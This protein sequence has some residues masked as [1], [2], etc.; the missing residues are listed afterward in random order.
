[1]S[2][3]ESEKKRRNCAVTLYLGKTLKGYEEGCI[4]VWGEKCEKIEGKNNG[5]S[6]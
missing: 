1:M 6:Q 4:S 2:I 3:P 5:G